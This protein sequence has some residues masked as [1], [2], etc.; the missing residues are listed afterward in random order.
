MKL[1]NIKILILISMV[2]GVLASCGIDDS[3]NQSPNAINEDNIQSVEGV[4]GLSIGLQVTLGDWYQRDRSRI[5]SVWTWQMGAPPGIA[6]GQMLAWNGYQMSQDGPTDDLWILAYRAN[7]IASDIIDNTPEVQ[8]GDETTNPQIQNVYLGMAKAAKGLIFGELAAFYGSIPV[9]IKA[10]EPASFI[11]QT[12]A[13]QQAQTMLDEAAQHFS[14]TTDVGRDLNFAGASAPWLEVVH[15]L[16]ARYYLHVKDYQSALTAAQ[17][18]IS[19]P[20]NTWNA[21]FSDNAGEY[22]SWGMWVQN[23]GEPLRAEM[24]FIRLLKEEDGDARLSEYFT[25]ADAAEGEYYGYN[26]HNVAYADDPENDITMTARMKKYS[27]FAENFP[28][29][30][31][32]ENILILAECKARTGDLD[33]A[34]MELNKIRTAATLDDFDSD[35]ADEIIAEI[36]KQKN[37]ELYLEGQNYHDMRRTGT[38]PDAKK[39]VNLRWIY[40]ES[41]INANPNVPEDSDALINL[42]LHDSYK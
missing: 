10:L 9:D 11:D 18:G 27:T 34:L 1:N 12:A 17:S 8:F 38:L 26:I 30:S 21:I 37:L 3:I 39:G 29:I 32:E 20:E 23:E 35:N 31:Y 40:P 41:E 22:A 14:N 36:L 2:F 7:K 15:S 28:L 24:H 6:R 13:Y 42:I 19:A 16:K 33:G 4:Q 5:S 25:P